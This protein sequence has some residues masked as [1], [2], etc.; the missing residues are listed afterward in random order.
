MPLATTAPQLCCILQ[1]ITLR[2]IFVFFNVVIS[3]LIPLSIQDLIPVDLIF[4]IIQI[5]TVYNLNYIF[6][7]VI[8]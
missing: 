6:I 3:F 5:Q 1:N 8:S 2:A 4:H 7:L